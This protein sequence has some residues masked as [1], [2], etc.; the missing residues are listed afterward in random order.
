MKELHLHVD[1]CVVGGGLAGLCAALAAARRGAS[2]ALVQDRPVLGG[3]SSG[4][5]RMHVCGAHGPNRRETGIVEELFLD[6]FRYNARPSYAGWDAVLYGKAQY[7][8]GLE[9]VLNASVCAAR[10]DGA[11]IRSVRAWQCTAQRWVEVE[12]ALFADCSGDAV[13][14]PLSGADFRMGREGRAEHG[15]SIAPLVPDTRTMGMSCLFQAREYPDPQPFV[16]F[17]WANRYETAADLPARGMDVFRT[18]FWWM[19]VGGMV[20]SIGDTETCREELLRIAYG[21]WD[22]LKNRS[23][24]RDRYARLALDWIG[25]LPGKRESRRYYGDHILTQNDVEAGGRFPDTVAYGGWSMDDHFPEGFHSRSLVGTTYH[26][27]PSP[28]GIPYRSLYS[29]NVPNLFCAGRDISATHSALSSTRVMATCA[30]EGQAVGTAAAIA[31][32]DGLDPRG[33]GQSRLAELQQALMDDDCWLPGFRRGIPSACAAAML[34]AAAGD[35]APLRNGIDRPDDASD[36]AWRAPVGTPVEYLFPAP[37]HFAEARLVFDSD[38]DRTDPSRPEGQTKLLNMRYYVGLGDAPFAPPATLVR[39]FRLETLGADGEWSLAAHVADNHQRLVRVPL[40][41]H[42]LGL[43][44]VVER[45]WGCDNPRV[46][47]FDAR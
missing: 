39:D 11:R 23:P 40:S 44:L 6:N 26:P 36:N 47:A 12:A 25:F 18:N 17:P 34:R 2:V 7:Q 38:L 43:R 5:V 45:T 37:A 41:G 33:V 9:L 1:F 46:F 27:A 13:L 16:P 15:E 30:L 4:E 14:A 29:R 19:E 32:R 20:D 31:A 35:P 28:Y 42:C 22:Y 3:N 8:K 10:M 21:V 24:D